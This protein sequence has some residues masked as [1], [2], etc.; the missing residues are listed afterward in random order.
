MSENLNI[1]EELKSGSGRAVLVAVSATD[2]AES[3]HRSLNELARLL[4]TA[5]GTEAGR[6]IQNRETPDNATYIGSGKVQELADFV[7]E[8]DISLVVFDNELTPSQI[9]NL[10]NGIPNVR[11]IDRTM[12]ILDIFALHA[13]T[14]EGKLQVEIACLRYTAPR[15]TG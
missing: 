15:L 10:E 3:C 11:V 2:K 8:E 4:E 14:G 13:V 9:K 5:G 6:I 12:L 7:A 1:T